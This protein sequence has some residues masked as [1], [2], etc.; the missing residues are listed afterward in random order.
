MLALLLGRIP[1]SHLVHKEA[2]MHALLKAILPPVQSPSSCRW[3]G[4]SIDDKALESARRHFSNVD[5][6]TGSLSQRDMYWIQGLVELVSDDLPAAQTLLLQQL[7]VSPKGNFAWYFLGE[8]SLR[9]GDTYSAI[10]QWKL[11]GAK[12]QLMCLG[13]ELT[14]QGKRDEALATLDA[15]ADLDPL[16]PQPRRLAAKLVEEVDGQ[17]ALKRYQEIIA[18][19]PEWASGYAQCGKVLFNAGQ[20]EQAIP[21]LEQAM[22]HNPSSSSWI[23]EMLGRSYAA[24]GQWNKAMKAYQQAIIESPADHRIYILTG[25]TACSM[26]QPERARLCYEQAAS[27]GNRTERLEKIIVHISQSGQCP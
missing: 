16:D 18:I 27:L 10:E 4:T 19:R 21:F 20:Y 15:A 24:L 8:I 14:E 5:T 7:E 1:F 11:A 23:L 2:G 22:Q 13:R 9:T 25:D 26:G 3:V 17:Q 12:E 6:A